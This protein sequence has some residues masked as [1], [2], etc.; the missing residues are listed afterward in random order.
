MVFDLV[1]GYDESI[2]T[3]GN[4]GLVSFN[5]NAVGGVRD[6]PTNISASIPGAIYLGDTQITIENVS[7]GTK[8][9]LENA[10]VAIT[11]EDGL[12]G[13]GYTDSNGDVTI[14]V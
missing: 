8:S 12:K 5:G 1:F 4:L 13:I 6:T 7:D 2:M 11:F 3:G 9:L 14:D 10:R